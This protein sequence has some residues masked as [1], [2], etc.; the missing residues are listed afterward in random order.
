MLD[1]VEPSDAEQ[2]DVKPE[3]GRCQPSGLPRRRGFYNLKL[4]TFEGVTSAHATLL[5]SK[6]PL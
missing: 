6:G 2:A 4:A 5:R 1:A 3:D